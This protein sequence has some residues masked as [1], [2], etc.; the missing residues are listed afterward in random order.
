MAK[1]QNGNGSQE[2]YAH[3]RNVCA[4][5][6]VHLVTAQTDSKGGVRV[7]ISPDPHRPREQS[8]VPVPPGRRFGVDE[9]RRVLEIQACQP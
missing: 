9:L 5:I 4:E 2:T 8:I 1:R 6:G 3:Y 7:V